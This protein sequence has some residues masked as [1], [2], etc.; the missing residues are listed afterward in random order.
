MRRVREKAA[1]EDRREEGEPLR[2]VRE[3]YRSEATPKKEKVATSRFGVR[4]LAK[5][6]KTPKKTREIIREQGLD[7]Y[8][9]I[10]F[11]EAEDIARNLYDA[12]DLETAYGLVRGEIKNKAGNPLHPAVRIRKI[13]KRITRNLSTTTSRT[14]QLF[15]LRI[16]H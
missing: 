16:F 9:K 8:T 6:S 13:T 15:T 3:E 10:S 7:Q 2:G 11:K 14:L 12:N 4:M 1:E 5:D